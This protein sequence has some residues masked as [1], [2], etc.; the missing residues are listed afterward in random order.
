MAVPQYIVDLKV[1]QAR[2]EEKL[3]GFLEEMKER[4]ELNRGQEKRLRKVENRQHWYAGAGTGVGAL[5]TTLVQF[6]IGHR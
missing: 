5:L 6:A 1:G 2:L 3:D 4:D